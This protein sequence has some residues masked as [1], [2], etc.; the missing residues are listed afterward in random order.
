MTVY[1]WRVKRVGGV[2][3]RMKHSPLLN[4]Y[5]LSSLGGLF[6]TGAGQIELHITPTPRCQK[7]RWQKVILVL[8]RPHRLSY[9]AF[10]MLKYS[11]VHAYPSISTNRS[12][13]PYN[14]V[15]WSLNPV[16]SA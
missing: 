4:A 12:P 7:V 6:D 14:R 1:H 2:D 10:D 5:L 16:Y 9:E 8:P 15:G 3:L 11:P 13:V